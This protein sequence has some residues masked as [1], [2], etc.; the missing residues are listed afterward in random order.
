[1]D[2]WFA[3]ARALG[4]SVEIGNVLWRQDDWFTPPR[5]ADDEYWEFLRRELG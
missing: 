3:S 5:P 2:R 4:A 1:L